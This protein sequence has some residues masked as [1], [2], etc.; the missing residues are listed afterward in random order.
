MQT[1]AKLVCG[2]TNVHLVMLTGCGKLRLSVGV[3]SMLVTTCTTSTL[4]SRWWEGVKQ[5]SASKI[6]S[7][8]G[9][10]LSPSDASFAPF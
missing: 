4:G 8:L 6:V 7:S 2:S 10:A 3:L 1:S 9:P 5:H